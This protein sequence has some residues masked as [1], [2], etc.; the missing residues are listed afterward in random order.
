M[1]KQSNKL[2]NYLCK[3]KII[4]S[5][6]LTGT[7]LALTFFSCQSDIENLDLESSSANNLS[8]SSFELGI[9]SYSASG[10]QG[11]SPG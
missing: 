6:K 5:L 3:E 10:A 4:N 2:Q 11:A 1:K 8:S 7:A 9:S